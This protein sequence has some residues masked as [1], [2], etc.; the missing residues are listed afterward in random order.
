MARK[1]S[2]KKLIEA[3]VKYDGIIVD[4]AKTFKVHR[5]TV[6]N[7]IN[8][9]E[10]LK[11][12]VE[13][14]KNEL[15]DLAKKGLRFHLEKNSEKSIHFVLER[16]GRKDGFGKMIQVKETSKFQDALEEMSDEELNDLLSSTNRKLN[17]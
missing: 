14:G 4:I 2:K 7:W 12:L 17:E 9:D 16:L 15:V 10:D 8:A 3:I 11:Q 6:Y 1:P 5:R 13:D